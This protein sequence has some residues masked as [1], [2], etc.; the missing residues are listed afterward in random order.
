M[1]MNM[2]TNTNTNAI[3]EDA[4][5]AEEIGTK[6][7]HLLSIYP[8]ISPTML[9]GG[10]GPAMKPVLWRP[11]LAALIADNKVVQEQESMLTPT[12]RYN[13]Y[14]KLMLPGTQV[15]WNE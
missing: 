3:D 14:T 15:L 1:N 4:V 10:L 8:I 6:I 13:T 9:Q 11:I 5:T 12:E 7:L 2:N